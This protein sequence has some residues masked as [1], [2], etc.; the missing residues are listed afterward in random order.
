MAK[1]DE[2]PVIA[3]T[4]LRPYDTPLVERG[5]VW[6][7]FTKQHEEGFVLTGWTYQIAFTTEQAIEVYQNIVGFLT[8]EEID[9]A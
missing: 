1:A 9:H 7:P 8:A 2:L 5:L 4:Q 6:N 3:S